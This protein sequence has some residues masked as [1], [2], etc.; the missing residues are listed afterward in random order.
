MLVRRWISCLRSEKYDSFI[1]TLGQ[2][3][4]AVTEIFLETVL[5]PSLTTAPAA[6]IHRRQ[7]QQARADHRRQAP[8]EDEE[9]KARYASVES[10][11][12]FLREHGVDAK[13][14]AK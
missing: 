9:E 11:I 14:F 1:Q 4:T 7:R 5:T 6:P 8:K 12:A 10:A 3:Q 2:V 13:D